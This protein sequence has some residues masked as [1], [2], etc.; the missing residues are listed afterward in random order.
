MSSK[1]KNS[2]N[3][4]LTDSEQITD[5]KKIS[6]LLERFTRHYTPLTVGIPGSDE[7][8]TSCIVAVEGK[9]L[10][11]DELVPPSGHPSLMSERTANIKGK[12][13]GI[14]IQFTT[15]LHHAGEKDNLQT[16]Y[17]QLPKLVEYLQRRLNFRAHI[18][19][20]MKLPVVI[21]NKNGG[22]FKGELHILS[23]GGA[24]MIFLPDKTIM[25]SGKLHE[26]AIELPESGWIYCTVELRHSK[27]IPS[28]NTQ[29]VG[30]QFIGLLPMQSRLIGRCISEL[31]REAIRKHAT[32]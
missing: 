28:R 26:C 29:F 17:M 15:T 3:R 8:Y 18:P 9:Y 30:A 24:G 4:P 16:Y 7:H 21:E 11:L 14:D 20:A 12:L 23:Y 5:N 22:L 19:V 6:K 10:L 25:Q 13:D 31:E 2:E 1:N 27:D 32:Y